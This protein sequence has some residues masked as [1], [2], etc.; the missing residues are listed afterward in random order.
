MQSI[1]Y[2]HFTVKS[3]F[4]PNV[5]VLHLKIKI[6]SMKE[7]FAF[8]EY[9][10]LPRKKEI[11]AVEMKVRARTECSCNL[12]E[13]ILYA[14]LYKFYYNDIGDSIKSLI[15]DVISDDLVLGSCLCS[16]S[17]AKCAKNRQRI[18]IDSSQMRICKNLHKEVQSFILDKDIDKRY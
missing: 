16:Q 8:S 18:F 12:I 4:V 11:R 3:N 10:Y 14:T 17:E 2:I 6:N 5:R 1:G 9:K 15:V 13:N 7:I